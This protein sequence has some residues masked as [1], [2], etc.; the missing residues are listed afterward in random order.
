VGRLFV[1]LQRSGWVG[2]DVGRVAGE[3]GI[4]VV[5]G[6]WAVVGCIAQRGLVGRLGVGGVRLGR[7]I[8]GIV[9]LGLF[10]KL[11]WS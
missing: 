1:V 6:R 7:G 10:L 9:A 4:V 8:G 2:H 5:E 3:V 11:E